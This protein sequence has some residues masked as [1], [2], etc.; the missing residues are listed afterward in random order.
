MRPGTRPGMRL[1][2]MMTEMTT[3]YML[4]YNVTRYQRMLIIVEPT[5]HSL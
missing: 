3:Y 1:T 5:I 4:E 2:I